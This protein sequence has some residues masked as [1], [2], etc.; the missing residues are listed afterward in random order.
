MYNEK[1]RSYFFRDLIVKILLVLLFIF[2]LM[3]L[4]PM[5]NLNPFYD[6]IFTQNMNNMT[7]AA[8][9]YY[10]VARL[11]QK[12][13]ES[14]RLTLGD[15]VDN[16][17]LIEFTDSNGKA[18]DKNKSYVEVTKKNNEYIFKTNLSC[19]KQEDYVI[20]YFGCYDVCENGSCTTV[21]DKVDNSTNNNTNNNTNSNSN[22]NSDNN[23][24]TSISETII[25]SAKGTTNIKKITEYQ[26]Y[27][28]TIATYIEK[29]TCKPG[30]TLKGTKCLKETRIDKVEDAS[31][32]CLSGYS[33][34]ELTKKC[35]KLDTT[36]VDATLS[37]PKGYIYATSM[38]KCIKGS[39][40]EVDATLTYKCSEGTLVGTSCVITSTKIVDAEK[41]YTCEKGRLSG[42]KCIIDTESIV[43]AE[44]VYSCE[45]GTLNGTKCEISST[46][47]KPAEKVYT[48]SEG[49]LNGTKCKIT[50]S[51][52]K[53]YTCPSGYA[54]SGTTCKTTKAA[55]KYCKEGKLSGSN[56]VI[57]KPQTCTYT[58][59]ACTIKTYSYKVDKV[60]TTTFT[61]EFMQKVSSGYQY[62]E[63]TRK[64]QCTG[65]GTTTK[66]ASL[67]CDSS[68]WTLSGSTCTYTKAATLS[69]K[70]SEGTLSGTN[71]IITRDAKL[72]YK[73]KEGT[74]SGTNCVIP[75]NSTVD[76]KLTYKC[77]EGTLSGT[78][79]IIPA[80]TSIDA[81]L[82]YR[83]N[84]GTMNSSNKCEIKTTRKVDARKS[85]TCQVGKLVGTKCIIKDI[86]ETNPVYTCKYGTLNGTSCIITTTDSREPIYYCPSNYTLADKKCYTTISESDIIDATAVYKSKS[87]T[88]YKWSTKEYIEGWTR[89]G[90]TRI[91]EIEIT[92]RGY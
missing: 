85:Y 30:Y 69:Y 51:A 84:E 16:K 77:N 5:P 42:T 34:N 71:C 32:K 26:F 2:L 11:P 1:E 20:E 43:D 66:P 47:T 56:C 6:K 65:G 10:T 73:C 87:E 18:C 19:S 57:T 80:Q 38:D 40:D 7:N 28:T 68:A 24:K 17:M 72:S 54:L 63:C 90:K 4:F 37:C 75:A 79:C 50:K 23:S 36:T 82:S 74:L 22:S 52:T 45:T 60:S 48:C 33:Y 12:D 70:C 9:G 55:T 21:I 31:L 53:Q 46:T 13:G 76:A 3:W 83:C 78:K 25:E 58:K 49:S 27:K 44:K 88:V 29:Y 64:Y 86:I 62:N 91:R 14:K 8:R 81:K 35:E 39:D 41:V 92:S 67:K 59:W 61:R 15:M 89:T